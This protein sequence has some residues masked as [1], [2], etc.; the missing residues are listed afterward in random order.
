[1]AELK[2][3]IRNI[4]QKLTGKIDGIR[5]AKG[6]TGNGIESVVRN[7]D[8]SLT[9]NFTDGTNFNTGSLRGEKGERAEAGI[10]EFSVENGH[11]IYTRTDALD[12]DFG[13][14]DGRLV[15]EVD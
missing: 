10:M 11:V 15:L 4:T 3:S 2:G 9:L 6:D 12:I 13:L 5:G 14:A 7:D 8:Y 1:M